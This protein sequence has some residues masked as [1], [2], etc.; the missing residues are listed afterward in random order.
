MKKAEN[1][2]QWN[3]QLYDNKHAFVFQFGED[4]LSLLAPK[5]GENILDLGCGTGYLTQQIAEAGANVIGI[6]NSPAMI[7]QAQQQYPT[8][9]FEVK[10][11]SNF[12]FDTPFDAVFS[13]ATLHWISQKE[14]V[15]DCVYESLKPGGRF[16]AEFGGKGNVGKIV[17]SIRKILRDTGFHQHAAI[18]F[19]YFPSVGEYTTLLENRGFRVTFAAHFDRETKLNDQ[20]NGVIDWIEMFGSTFFEG[21]SASEKAGILMKVKDDLQ[22]TCFREGNWFAD[23]KRLRIVAVKE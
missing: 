8:V 12:H 21:I 23:Y 2:D 7:A 17:N 22:P 16:V 20:Q 10:D 6:D 19:W 3:A 15:I 13:N 11:G 14:K 4:V 1:N 9:E 5:E 18:D